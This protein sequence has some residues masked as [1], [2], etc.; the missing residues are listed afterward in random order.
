MNVNRNLTAERMGYGVGQTYS[1]I[2][3]MIDGERVEF[4]LVKGGPSPF[5][6]KWRVVVHSGCDPAQEGVGG[7]EIQDHDTFDE[8]H[9]AFN[10][11]FSTFLVGRKVRLTKWC[12]SRV[13]GDFAPG[14]TGTVYEFDGYTI[15]VKMDDQFEALDEYD[16]NLHFSAEGW[17]D[18][19]GRE[20]LTIEDFLD[21]VEFMDGS[22]TEVPGDD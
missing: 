13:V 1:A 14:L 15:A 12:G 6:G 16:N 21:S 2:G 11:A 17:V 5:D 18:E 4:A 10:E 3:L 9:V 7:S 22:V 8:A 20:F 19:N